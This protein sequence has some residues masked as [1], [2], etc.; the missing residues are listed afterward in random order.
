MEP[1]AYVIFS[2]G[3]VSLYHILKWGS[4]MKKVGNHCS[5]RNAVPAII[6][7]TG[8]AFRA[9]AAYFHLCIPYFC[10]W[11]PG[12]FLFELPY[13]SRYKAILSSNVLLQQ[14]SEV[15]IISSYSAKPVWNWLPQK[16]PTLTL[17]VGYAPASKVGNCAVPPDH[18]HSEISFSRNCILPKHWKNTKT[19]RS[20]LN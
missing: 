11:K 12:R 18:L 5:N 15:Y 19:R 9:V 1:S 13:C 3:V 2:N 17:L 16:Y 6:S 14:C 20:Y 8:T 4:E 7:F 10:D